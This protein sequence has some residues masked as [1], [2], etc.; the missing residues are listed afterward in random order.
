[1]S[2][3]SRDILP[4]FSTLKVE[5]AC[6]S[7]TLEHNHNKIRRNNQDITIEIHITMKNKILQWSLNIG[8]IVEVLCVTVLI[9]LM[10]IIKTGI[11]QL[12]Y[13]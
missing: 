11:S 4:P 6:Y 1:M 13:R 7:E 9:E 8:V 12:F 3:F 2:T 10:V 5:T